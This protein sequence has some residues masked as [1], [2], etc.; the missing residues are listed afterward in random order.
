MVDRAAIEALGVEVLT[1]PLASETQDYARHS[2]ARLAEA[3]MEI[4]R[5]RADTRIY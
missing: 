4:Y 2:V 5:E 3:V 1:R